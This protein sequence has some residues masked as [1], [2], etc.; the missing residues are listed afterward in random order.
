[1]SISSGKVHFPED[2]RD[3]LRFM[4]SGKYSIESIITHVFAQED[5]A[6]AIETAGLV[7]EALN[8]VIRF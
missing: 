1:M 7:D 6:K 8:V 2:V 4:E 5:L 3:V